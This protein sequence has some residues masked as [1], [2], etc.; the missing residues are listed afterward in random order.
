MAFVK[1]PGRYGDELVRPE[2]IVRIS[3]TEDPSESQVFV[4][5]SIEGGTEDIFSCFR[6][7]LPPDDVR[8][9][10]ENAEAHNGNRNPDH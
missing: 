4:A 6:C 10:I 7:E 9:R 5:G 2:A 3:P 8:K 1:L